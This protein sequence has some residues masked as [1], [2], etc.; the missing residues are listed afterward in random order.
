[1]LKTYTWEEYY[2]KFYDWAESTQVRNLYS[3]TSLGSADEVAEIISELSNKSAANYLLKKAVNAKIAFSVS[4]LLEFLWNCANALATAAVRNSAGKLT[5]KDIEQ[6]VDEVD[7]KVIKEICSKR[8]LPLPEY[9]RG[10][11]NKVVNKQP[12]KLGFFTSLGLALGLISVV[13]KKSQPKKH[14]GRCN[15]DCANCPPHYGYRYGR[16]Y[17]GHGHTHGC[18]FGGNKC[19]GGKD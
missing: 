9:M 15:G 4:D 11:D 2:E 18:E 19:D 3:L 14:T 1:M 10:D 7:D 5:A 17:Y 16:W 12:K 13:E 8:K 6:L